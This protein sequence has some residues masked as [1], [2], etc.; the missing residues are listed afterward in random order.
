M[1]TASLPDR[2]ALSGAPFSGPL[3]VRRA[4]WNGGQVGYFK[5][6]ATSVG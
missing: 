2:L 4:P 1:E 3:A 5:N 6:N